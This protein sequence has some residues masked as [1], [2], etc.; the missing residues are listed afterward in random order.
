MEDEFSL[1]EIQ[2]I[3]K[4]LP[5]DKST[6]PDGF[7]TDFFKKCWNI[8]SSDILDL[9]KAFYSGSLCTRSINGSYITL[10]AK[11]DNPITVNDYMPVSLLNVSMKII[12]KLL[13]NRLQEKIIP[14]VH[15]NNMVLLEE[16]QFKTIEL[17]LMN[18]SMPV[19]N[20]TKR[21]LSSN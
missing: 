17:G 5:S 10:I 8:M 6:G 15:K 4:H 3:V 1:L 18:I 7:N 9:W 21:L 12:T 20:Q 11:K 19:T 16:G 2:N 14:L 13:A